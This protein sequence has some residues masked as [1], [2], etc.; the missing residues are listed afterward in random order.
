VRATAQS[1]RGL[2][3]ELR[4]ASLDEL[5]LEPALGALVERV[6]DLHALDVELRYEK[7]VGPARPA[8]E[9]ESAAY[10]LVQEA[11]TN[12]IKHARARVARVVVRQEDGVLTVLVSDDG[13][14]FSVGASTEGF[15]L[16]G[17]RER[18]ALVDGTLEIESEPGGGTTVH[19]SLPLVREEP[20]PAHAQ[21][22]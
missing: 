8:P 18:A 12:V 5:G 17:M 13:R 22:A 7:V 11:L 10:R 4:P 14:G 15:G 1:L 2:V 21:P 9:V 6:R 20:A 16:M 19:A 3:S